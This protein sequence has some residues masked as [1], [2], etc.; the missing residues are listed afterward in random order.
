[1]LAPGEG[2]D[3]APRAH[4]HLATVTYFFAGGSHFADSLGNEVVI[5]SGAVAWMHAGAGIVRAERTPDTFRQHGRVSHGIQAWAALPEALERS[6]PRFQLARA[7]EIPCVIRGGVSLRVLV[8]EAFGVR[9]PIE[10]SSPVVLV[11]A[12]RPARRR[13]GARGARGASCHLLRRRLRRA[14]RPQRRRGNAPPLARRNGGWAPARGGHDGALLRRR[15]ARHAFH[16]GGNFIASSAERLDGAVR[17][18][19]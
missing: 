9:S 7:D 14:F 6:A 5:K 17:E 10:T 13:S 8:G 2:V 1:M 16:A 19:S 11:E 18:L 3:I 4:A 15:A 12:E